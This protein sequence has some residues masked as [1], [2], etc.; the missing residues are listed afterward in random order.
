MSLLHWRSPDVVDKKKAAVL[1]AAIIGLPPATA[2]EFDLKRRPILRAGKS[3][4]IKIT[5][6][7]S[8]GDMPSA[9]TGC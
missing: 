5:F 8:G 1:A 9:G 7:F 4:F 2:S 3:Y 6:R